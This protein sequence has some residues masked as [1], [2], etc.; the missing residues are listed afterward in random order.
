MSAPSCLLCL[1]AFM[2]AA[3]ADQLPFKLF[4]ELALVG[5]A[6]LVVKNSTRSSTDCAVL[7]LGTARCTAFTFNK[8]QGEC[9]LKVS[10][11]E[12]S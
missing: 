4:P 12:S 11:V 8:E 2:G 3:V 5:T 7:C 6:N 1:L 9:Q 10:L